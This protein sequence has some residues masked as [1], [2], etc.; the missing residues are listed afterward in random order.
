MRYITICQTSKD[1]NEASNLVDF[2][3]GIC[4]YDVDVLWRREG[5]LDRSLKIP[6]ITESGLHVQADQSVL[7]GLLASR[8]SDQVHLRTE[9]GAG[10][11]GAIAW[12]PAFSY[13]VHERENSQVFRWYRRCYKDCGSD[14]PAVGDGEA[15]NEEKA[16]EEKAAEE[17][18]QKSNSA[19]QDGLICLLDLLT[20]MK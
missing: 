12:H 15:G 7:Q 14:E 13:N 8:F 3:S 17:A 18:F 4:L 1:S 9:T 10:C 16:A 5:F 19:R 6:D 2:S 20:G 11:V